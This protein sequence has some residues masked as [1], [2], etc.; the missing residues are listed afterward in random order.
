MHFFGI[1]ATSTADRQWEVPPR[2]ESWLMVAMMQHAI[3]CIVGPV[4]P[5]LVH[6]KC[7]HVNDTPGMQRMQQRHTY[8][9]SCRGLLH[10]LR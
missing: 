2:C 1:L 7:C 8:N 9:I 6:S 5:E 3:L 4:R 10:K